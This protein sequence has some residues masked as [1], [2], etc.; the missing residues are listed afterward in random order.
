MGDRNG[1][2]FSVEIEIEMF[3]VR[4]SK[5]T[6]FLCVGRKL[7]GLNVW[8]EIDLVFVCG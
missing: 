7:L 2:G 6:W 1:I 3:F 5:L 8:I 4:G